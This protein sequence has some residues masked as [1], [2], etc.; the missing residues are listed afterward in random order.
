ML[1]NEKTGETVDDVWRQQTGRTPNR[2][3]MWARDGKAWC[4]VHAG[5][6]FVTVMAVEKRACY[7]D[8]DLRVEDCEGARVVR[9]RNQAGVMVAVRRKPGLVV[10][11]YAMSCASGE[12]GWKFYHHWTTETLPKEK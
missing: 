3:K 11:K 2:Y 5:H 4:F 6:D 12:W 9:Q 1:F 10:A 8:R 7:P